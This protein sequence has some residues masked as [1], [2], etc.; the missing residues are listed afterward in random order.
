M[1]V[2]VI[3]HISS[4]NR[5]RCTHFDSSKKREWITVFPQSYSHS[6]RCTE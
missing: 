2:A 1:V 5:N 6:L 3:L 4:I